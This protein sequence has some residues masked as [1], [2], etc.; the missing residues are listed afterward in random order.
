MQWRNPQ[1]LHEKLS[2]KL[3]FDFNVL[4]FDKISLKT[5]NAKYKYD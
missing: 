4:N 1:D 3:V 2:L 5:K